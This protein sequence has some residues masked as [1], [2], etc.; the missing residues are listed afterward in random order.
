ML[1]IQMTIPVAGYLTRMKIEN[2]GK[3][4]DAFSRNSQ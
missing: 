4:D 2:Y 1:A 3:P